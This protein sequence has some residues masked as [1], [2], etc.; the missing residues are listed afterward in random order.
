MPDKDPQRLRWVSGSSS[1]DLRKRP[2]TCWNGSLEAR[3]SKRWPEKNPSTRPQ[4]TAA[5]WGKSILRP[6]VR[7]CATPFEVFS[8]GRYTGVVRIPTGYAV[9]LVLAD[10]RLSILQDDN[11]PTRILAASATGAVQITLP[12]AGLNE[13]DAVLLGA[14]KPDDWNTDLRAICDART[15]PIA[16]LLDRLER[17]PITADDESTLD[18]VEGQYAWA[19]LHAYLGDMAKAIERWRVADSLAQMFVTRAIADDARNDGHRL[20]SQVGDG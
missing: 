3:I 7:S 19:Q 6:C 12:V 16:E 2:R 17:T 15:Q 4:A 9:L 18:A 5:T 8:R 14:P 1:S 10:R 20:L 11:N 13:A